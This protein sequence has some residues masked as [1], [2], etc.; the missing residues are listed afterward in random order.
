MRARNTN[1]SSL[2]KRD[3]YQ[4][5]ACFAAFNVFFFVSTFFICLLLLFPEFD[6][7]HLCFTFWAVSF[8]SATFACHNV[9]CYFGNQRN[10]NFFWLTEG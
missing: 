3:V 6:F 9:G 8:L 10:W 2:E 5:S 1:T 7:L 4:A